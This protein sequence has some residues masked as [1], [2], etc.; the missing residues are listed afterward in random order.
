MVQPRMVLPSALA[1]G[2]V[3]EQGREVVGAI[4][5]VTDIVG[6]IRAR[7]A[8]EAVLGIISRC[9]TA[10][11]MQHPVRLPLPALPIPLR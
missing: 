8:F 2:T 1:A 4:R 5:R 10:V 11:A 9:S 6:E 3:A 7:C